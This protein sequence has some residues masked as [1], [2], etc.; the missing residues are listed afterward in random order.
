[1]TEQP[2]QREVLDAT[3][4][5]NVGE[6]AALRRAQS[7][8]YTDTNLSAMKKYVQNEID[9]E[10]GRLIKA[11]SLTGPARDRAYRAI[12]ERVVRSAVAEYVD[13]VGGG[14]KWLTEFMTQY[15]SQRQ[16][17][18][19]QD[20]E[21]K[22]YGKRKVTLEVGGESE[23]EMPRWNVEVD[24]P[25]W[26]QGRA[27]EFHDALYGRYLTGI[28][29]RNVERNRAEA[30]QRQPQTAQQRI[31]AAESATAKYNEQIIVKDEQR[32]LNFRATA[33]EN[34]LATAKKQREKD[35]KKQERV[36]YWKG[37]DRKATKP[38]S[39]IYEKITENPGKTGLVIGAGLVAHEALEIGA[40]YGQPYASIFN[41]K[42]WLHLPS[43]TTG[44]SNA[45]LVIKGGIAAFALG[46]MGLGAYRTWRDNKH[47][48]AP[49]EYEKEE[50]AK[51]LEE[52]RRDGE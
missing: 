32:E 7:M 40:P 22:V 49:Q 21:G 16:Q 11:N 43:L 19:L 9:S 4:Q 28:I 38:F 51:M 44:D 15:L 10:F 46:L 5:A 47:I 6:T 1:M 35:E 52:A 18:R 2:T 50:V 37:V 24:E 31:E 48:A 12:R 29:Q 39:W 45:D 41:F 13:S 34:T 33:L 27:E 20:A 3:T 36:E 17:W 42:N 26:V 25:E 23:L 30:G 14:D 8:Q